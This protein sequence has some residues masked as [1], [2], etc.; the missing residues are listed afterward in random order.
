M[1]IKFI[2]SVGERSIKSFYS[3]YE[4][5][6][7]TFVCFI[8]MFNPKSYNPAMRMVLV[9]QI[10]FTAVGILPLFIT[11]AV[12][13]GSVIIGVVIFIATEYS[14]QDKIGSIIITFV[15]DEFSPFFT[16]LL[17][18]LRSGAAV[19]TEI[20]VMNVN[21][22]LDSLRAYKI[23]LIDYL[24]LPRIISGMLSVTALS[25]LFAIIM[26]SSGYIFTFFYMGMDFY[27]YSHLLINAIM[28]NDLLILFFKGI[29]FGVVIML[30]PIYSGL[31]TQNSY[32]NIPI[33]VL[34]G[35]VKLFVYIFFIE[36]VSL[37][38]QAL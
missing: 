12:L 37:L 14:L 26:L 29:S 31:K 34:N 25:I 7:F 24:F 38:I 35:M 5:L 4:V 6:H 9:K 8:H 13:F 33:S 23:D 20:A 19:N 27:T 18:S 36:V 15:V 16:A 2:E 1:L 17:I 30:I 21:R 11:M 28:V 3:F 32:S 10:Y 22:E